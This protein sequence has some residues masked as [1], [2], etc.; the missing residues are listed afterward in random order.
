MSPGGW[1]MH[2]PPESLAAIQAANLFSVLLWLRPLPTWLAVGLP[3]LAGVCLFFA[4]RS[5][6]AQTNLQPVFSR[7]SDEVPRFREFPSVYLYL[8][9]SAILF[10]GSIVGAFYFAP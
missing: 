6:I 8:L 9:G 3:A 5:V 2:S 1:G 10:V 7:W 4:N